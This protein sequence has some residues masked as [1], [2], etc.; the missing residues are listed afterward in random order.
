MAEIRHDGD[1]EKH[2]VYKS[3]MTREVFPSLLAF[4]LA[5]KGKGTI[6]QSPQEKEQCSHLVG[7][8]LSMGGSY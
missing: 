7:P 4:F 2:T 1:G 6:Q 3:R 5:Q 8:F